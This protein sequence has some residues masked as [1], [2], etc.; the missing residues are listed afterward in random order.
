MPMVQVD[1][2]R[3]V[4]ETKGAAISQAIHAGLIPMSK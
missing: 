2:R 3:D 4:F 1:L